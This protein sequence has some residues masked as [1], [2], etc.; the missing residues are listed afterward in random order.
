MI[1]VIIATLNDERRL[2]ATLAPLVPAAMEGLVREL[3]V[4][5][6]G[7]TD[8]TFDIADD[9][10]ARFIRSGGEAAS[11]VLEG[12]KAAKGPWLLVLDPGVRLDHGWEAAAL[13]HMNASTGPA[14][15]RLERGEGGFLAKLRAP[16]ARAVLVM[17]AERL[18]LTGGR[19]LDARG[20]V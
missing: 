10:G 7:S 17:K 13:K 6:G 11:R 14:R 8:A 16:G 20:W 9:A 18:Q 1:S 3:V 19:R 4:V 5:D 12:A 15:F 2:T